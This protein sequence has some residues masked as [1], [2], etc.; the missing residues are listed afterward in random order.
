VPH[1]PRPPRLPLAIIARLIP[2]GERAEAIADLRAEFDQRARDDGASSGRA[3]LWRQA[4]RSAPAMMRWTWWRART[5]YEPRSSAFRPR[6]PI[7][8][9]WITD[10]RYAVR[11]LR[12]SPAYSI[13]S[14]LT[15]ALGVGGTAAVFGIAKP[16]LVDSLPYKNANEVGAFWM[17]GWWTEEE[18]LYLRDKF[19]GF[20]AVAAYRQGDATIRDGDAPARLIP[21]IQTSWELFDVLGA[22]P[23]LG[24]TL[25]RGDDTRGAEPVA[26]ISYTLWQAL[27]GSDSI[28]GKRLTLDGQQRTVVGVMPRAFW[29]PTPDIQLWRADPLDPEGRNGSYAFVG[30]VAPGGDVA[31]LDGPLQQLT[32]TIGARFQYSPKADKTKNAIVRPLRDDLLGTVK[33]A[34]IA[35]LAAMVLILAIA[36]TNVAAL[37]LG[38]IE[39]RATELAVRSAL[40]ASRGRITQQIVVEAFVLGG[41]AALVGAAFAASGFRLLTRA[42]PLGAWS[43]SASL[44]WSV[45]A[46]AFALALLA[47]LLV[48]VVP[49]VVLWRRE[50]RGAL[51]GGRTSG[52]QGRGGRLEHALV[53]AEIALAMLIATGAALFVRSVSNR[54]AINPGIDIRGVAIV[55][56]TASGDMNGAQ[57]RQ[58]LNAITNALASMPG[59]KHAAATMKTPLRGDGNSFGIT[60]EGRDDLERSFTF[61]RIGTPQYLQTV[62]IPLHAGRLFDGSDRPDSAEIS[63]IINE[64]LAAKYFPGENP[65][66]RYM[67]GGFNVRQRIIG[68]V[69]NVAEGSLKRDAEPTRYYSSDQAPWWN[70]QASLVILTARP[71]DAE[72]ILDEAR[73]TIQRVAPS[74]A[75]VGATTMERVFDTAVGPARQIMSLLSLLS[76]LALVLGGIGIYG[77]ISHFASRRRRDWAIRVALGL[78]GSGVVAHILRQGLALSLAGIACGAVAGLVLA[79]L[80]ASFLFGVTALD[81]LSFG[82]ASLILLILGTAAAFIPAR[83][84]GTVDPALVLREQ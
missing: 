29:F 6:G 13:L 70:T 45:F 38:Q 27:G 31:H 1:P 64:A 39:G 53:V 78:P 11:R 80:L 7:V 60:I 4:V 84:A 3:W 18:F 36:C 69:G 41:L 21:G 8:K 66:G 59:V 55:D 79:R 20:R 42:L 43:D 2:R 9:N 74:Y 5:G 51:S 72:A 16:L 56:V 47:V 63:V 81:P 73:R 32:K 52:I 28:V 76:A 61:F 83:R 30:H 17:P 24:R 62:G 23:L 26:V 58:T 34:L 50:L 35:T 49:I 44:D 65:L 48:A 46:A 68:V 22:R 15:L 19:A 54:Y 40:G 12:T 82:V 37:M 14:I 75:I 67:G 25:R 77:V 10:A 33:P 57:R 71:Q